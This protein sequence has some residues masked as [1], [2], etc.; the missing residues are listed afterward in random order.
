MN[1][2]SSLARHPEL[3][4][5]WTLHYAGRVGLRALEHAHPITPPAEIRP[6]I[7]GLKDAITALL[8]AIERYKVVAENLP[9]KHVI[10]IPNSWSPQEANAV[11]EFLHQMADAVWIAA[12]PK[13]VELAQQEAREQSEIESGD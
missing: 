12:E 8:A 10:A 1:E 5:L 2:P 4:Q 11:F 13:L 3:A 9:R 7:Q 6:A